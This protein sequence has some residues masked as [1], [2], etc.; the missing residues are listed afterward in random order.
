MDGKTEIQIKKKKR[1]KIKW[2]L[3]LTREAASFVIREKQI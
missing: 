2:L 3:N 1:K